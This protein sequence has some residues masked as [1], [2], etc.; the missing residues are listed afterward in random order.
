MKCL[1]F[2]GDSGFFL[3][4]AMTFF[5]RKCMLKY[6]RMKCQTTFKWLGQMGVCV[7][8]IYIYMIM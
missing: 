1:I 6:L 7:C 8:V 5:L 2:L 4:Q 3:T